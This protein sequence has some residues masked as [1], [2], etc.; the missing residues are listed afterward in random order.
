MTAAAPPYACPDSYGVC[1][2]VSGT[3]PALHT[4]VP[5]FNPDMPVI[6]TE[7]LVRAHYKAHTAPNAFLLVKF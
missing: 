4:E 7:H 6:H 3:G 1:R 2:A 5:V